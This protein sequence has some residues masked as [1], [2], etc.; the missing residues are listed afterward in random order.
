MK[1][2]WWLYLTGLLLC[3]VP[4]AA[5]VLDR[6]S[7]WQNAPEKKISIGV[8]I[9]L[10]L[11]CIPLWRQIRN[12]IKGFA[13]NPSAWGVWLALTIIFIIFDKV[14]AD[15]LYICWVALPSSVIGGFL[16]AW[17]KKKGADDERI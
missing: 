16:M 12:A 10:C 15:M 2:R 9:C 11:C 1:R 8:I 17:A 6:F 4:A 3:I 13:E 5:A 7:L 14:S